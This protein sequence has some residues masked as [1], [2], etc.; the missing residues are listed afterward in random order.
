MS[1]SNSMRRFLAPVGIAPRKVA[2]YVRR[3]LIGVGFDMSESNQ[4]QKSA[5]SAPN[6]S[7]GSGDPSVTGAESAVTPER[8]AELAAAA[9]QSAEYY[10]RLLRMTA[11]FEN[12]KKRAARER[13]EVRKA[14]TESMIG[15]LLPVLDNFDMAIGA[16]KAPNANLETIKA[17]VSMIHS[18]LK[19]VFT[20]SGLEEVDALNKPFDPSLHEAVSQQ[21]TTTVPEGTVVQQLRKGYRL[22]DRLLRPASVIVARAPEPT[23]DVPKN[24]SAPAQS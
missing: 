13:D 10:D 2:N 16:T 1:V 21:E 24:E 14:A 6:P 15:K 19:G 8:I 7:A 9:A 11:D 17:G 22:R 18:Q 12:F 23:V 4:E 3:L 5:E 20:D